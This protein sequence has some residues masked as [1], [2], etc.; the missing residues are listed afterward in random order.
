M[1][2]FILALAIVFGAVAPSQI[3]YANDKEPSAA[4]IAK[5]KKAFAAG[6]KL[7]D[8]GDFPEAIVKFKE[9]Y[10]LSK[11]PVL[12]YNIAF[13]NDQA[14]Q[15]DIALFYYRKFLTDAP[16]DAGQRGEVTDRVKVLEAKFA[17]TPAPSGPSKPE[18][19][20][21]VVIKPA[22]TYSAT[23]FQHQVVDVAP[24]KK[25]LDVTAFVPEDSGFVV[26]LYFR[27]AGEGKFSQKEMRWRY[28]ELVARVPPQKMIGESMQYYIE[29]KDQTGA[30]IT[31][32]GKSTS[33]NLVTLEAGA[34]E[35][36]YPDFS[37]E[38]TVATDAEVHDDD[39]S[40]D[41]LNRGGNRPRKPKNGRGVVDDDVDDNKIKPPTNVPGQGYT[42]VGSS[43]F[44]AVKWGSTATAG[45]M[46]GLS[47]TFYILAGNQADKIVED[48][49]MCGSP[50]CRMYDDYNRD[51][52][53]AGKRNQSI[54]RVTMVLG[55]GAAALA[56]YYWW[57]ELKAKK[58]GELKVTGKVP[59][60]AGAPE[61]SWSVVPS[62][63]ADDHQTFVGAAAAARF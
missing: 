61:T 27:T 58:R 53:D 13:A 14:G 2:R 62:F 29:V 35:R 56:G 51:L 38:G 32:S 7:F 52:E 34:T 40:D 43:K 46:L 20:G 47:V 17:P 25:P 22:G 42:D 18:P 45:A 31:R 16:A 15:E 59:G 24:P 54:H 12:L 63:G 57:K 1:K 39:T 37:E 49:L 26:T 3:A 8:A 10:N 30:V 48:S 28:K 44:T 23:D 19:R 5:A 4:D 9:S 33:P 6:K 41:P 55:V 60:A 21:P 50:P 36:F 11:N